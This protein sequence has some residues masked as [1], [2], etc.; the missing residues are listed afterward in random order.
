M[1]PEQLRCESVD[2]RSDIFSM[3]II[4]Y[5]MA[6]GRYPFKAD[7]EVDMVLAILK[8]PPSQVDELRRTLPH[9]LSRIVRH[10]LEKDPRHRS[11]CWSS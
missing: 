4:L 10:C 11:P 7:S 3:G 9:H 6:V 1:S 2:H 8:T 5:E